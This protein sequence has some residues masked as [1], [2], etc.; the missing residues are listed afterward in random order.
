[1][2]WIDTEF[3]GLKI[4]EPI[5]H[6]DNR[7]YFLESYSKRAWDID[8]EFVQD[9]EAKSNKGVLRGLHYQ[10]GA[11]AQSKLVRVIKGAVQDVVLDIRPASNTYGKH[12]SIV[13]SEENKKQLFVPKGFAHGYLV[14]ADDTIFVYKCDAFYD[15]SAEGGIFCKDLNLKIDWMLDSKEIIL[16]GKDELLPNFGNHVEFTV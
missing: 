16:S 5:V 15:K 10:S 1:M 4:F 8:I 6:Q 9:N 2:P 13:L 12:F 7:G 3:V 14:L 11:N